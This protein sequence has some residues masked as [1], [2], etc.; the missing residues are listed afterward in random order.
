VLLA[1][2]AKF[3]T[4]TYGAQWDNDNLDNHVHLAVPIEKHKRK[5]A[6]YP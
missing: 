6:E 5:A 1:N 2:I 4:I 3:N